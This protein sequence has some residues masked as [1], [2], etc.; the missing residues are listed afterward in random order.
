MC[1]PQ[2]SG[3]NVFLDGYLP[4][5]NVRFRDKA[6]TFD[7]ST[8]DN[9]FVSDVTAIEYPRLVK[10]YPSFSIEMRQARSKNKISRAATAAKR[11]CSRYPHIALKAL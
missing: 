3:I 4:S 1:Y 9:D 7:V 6:F 11:R 2:R 8:A 10:N 5:E